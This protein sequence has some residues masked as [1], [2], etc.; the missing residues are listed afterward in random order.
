ML[1]MG[2]ISSLAEGRDLVR[3]SFPVESYQ[4]EQNA[5]WEAAYQR[6]VELLV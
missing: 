4:P 1:A 5:A 3:R 2:Q 6:F